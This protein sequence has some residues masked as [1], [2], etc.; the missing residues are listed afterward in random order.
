M[1]TADGDW[2]LEASEARSA[3]NFGSSARSSAMSACEWNAQCED[4][5]KAVTR[6]ERGFSHVPPDGGPLQR[7]MAATTCSGTPA[8]ARAWGP[9]TRHLCPP[10]SRLP[11]GPTV[12]SWSRIRRS[13]GEHQSGALQEC[14]C[15]GPARN[16]AD[17]AKG[18]GCTLRLT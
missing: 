1:G 3:P 12:G 16:R 4:P 5:G 9:E 8:V 2:S 15:Q 7:P 6:S 10:Q 13:V 14:R 17:S 18:S 11:R